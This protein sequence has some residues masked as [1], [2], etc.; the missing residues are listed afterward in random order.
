MNYIGKFLSVSASWTGRIRQCVAQGHSSRERTSVCGWRTLDRRRDSGPP[1][2]AKQEWCLR[3]EL[4]MH[5]DYT[6]LQKE[7][8]LR[9]SFNIAESTTAL[10]HLGKQVIAIS[11]I[12]R[13]I[14]W[15]RPQTILT[16]R[17]TEINGA[18]R[19]QSDPPA[20]PLHLFLP[21]DFICFSSPLLQSSVFL[22]TL[23]SSPP[24]TL[25][26]LFS[27]AKICFHLSVVLPS[28]VSQEHEKI[29]WHEPRR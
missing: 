6:L 7:V 12:H 8:D 28:F 26:L 25:P 29:L 19:K 2:Q 23:I 17:L 18:P 24:P 13:N 16:S 20:P 3:P 5:A 27:F 22:S 4:L 9:L 10:S 11:I 14:Q 15:L 21:P 1:A